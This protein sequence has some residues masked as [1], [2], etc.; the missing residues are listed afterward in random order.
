[1]CSG[2]YEGNAEKNEPGRPLEDGR[3]ERRSE[4]SALIMRGKTTRTDCRNR[5]GKI[6]EE[7]SHSRCYPSCLSRIFEMGTNANAMPGDVAPEYGGQFDIRVPRP[8][9]ILSRNAARRHAVEQVIPAQ[10]VVP[11][12]RSPG[13]TFRHVFYDTIAGFRSVV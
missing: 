6:R 11:R 5:A 2:L 1:M 10:E 7:D 13:S 4:E 9:R 8:A 3:M 12:V